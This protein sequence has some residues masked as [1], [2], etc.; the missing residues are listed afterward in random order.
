M[1][2][3]DVDFFVKILFELGSV[4]FEVERF[5]ETLELDF[6][7]RISDCMGWTC[8][9]CFHSELGEWFEDEV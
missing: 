6:D 7:T 5:K 4:G 1:P 3:F 9:K 2:K 8:S